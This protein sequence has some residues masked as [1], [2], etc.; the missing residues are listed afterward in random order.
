MST[1]NKFQKLLCRTY[2]NGEYAHLAE[3]DLPD[4][5]EWRPLLDVC[6]DTLFKFLMLELAD[7]EGQPMTREIMVTR[8][9]QAHHDVEKALWDLDKSYPNE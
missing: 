2:C 9:E 4:Q 3:A 6:G 8:L 5:W 7:E 1:L